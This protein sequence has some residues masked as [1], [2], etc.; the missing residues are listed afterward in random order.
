MSVGPLSN[1]IF[2]QVRS[3]AFNHLDLLACLI[4]GDGV[5]VTGAE[6]NFENLEG[7]TIKSITTDLTFSVCTTTRKS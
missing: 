4:K 6:E 3:N 1:S 7:I 5:G 2:V